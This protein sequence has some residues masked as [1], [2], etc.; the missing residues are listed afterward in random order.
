MIKIFD[1]LICWSLIG[2]LVLA[3]VPCWA[4]LPVVLSP[5][6]M[7][8]ETTQALNNLIHDGYLG[9]PAKSSEMPKTSL[10]PGLV[11]KKIFKTIQSK[12]FHSSLSLSNQILDLKQIFKLVQYY[13]VNLQKLHISV[14][15]FKHV[16][17]QKIQHLQNE[18]TL[19]PIT[20]SPTISMSKNVSKT[21]TGKTYQDQLT[22]Q[23]GVL[24][25]QSVFLRRKLNYLKNNFSIMMADQSALSVKLRLLNIMFE[26]IKLQLIKI[27]KQD[28]LFQKQ[29]VDQKTN[30][31]ELNQDFE[32]LQTNVTNDEEDISILKQQMAGL[33]A[34]KKSQTPL[35]SFLNSKWIPSAALI[36]GLAALIVGIT[37]SQP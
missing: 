18:L 4:T 27:N 30:Y 20:S 8:A 35:D 1:V 26:N 33:L 5:T 34:N 22:N 21:S 17:K 19:V 31:Q 7:I 25:N 16:I 9:I 13:A 3:P 14:W 36:V 2:L 28:L 37:K 24:S 29:M 23:V 12:Q 6:P 10:Q 32:L 15:M 11:L